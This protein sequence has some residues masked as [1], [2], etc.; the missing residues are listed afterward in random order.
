MPSDNPYESPK[1][2]SPPA[3]TNR[4]PGKLVFGILLLIGMVPASAAAF[5]CCCL[6]GVMAVE[7]TSKP[8]PDQALAVGFGAR[9]VGGVAVLL[10][11]LFGGIAMIR[12]ANRPPNA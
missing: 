3:P 5:F 12:R 9:S 6:A 4:S 10:L 8:G 2:Q 11:M 1:T 7:D